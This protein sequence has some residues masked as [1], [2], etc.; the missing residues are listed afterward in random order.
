LAKPRE[1]PS[2]GDWCERGSVRC[3][4]KRRGKKRHIVQTREEIRGLASHLGLKFEAEAKVKM[5]GGAYNGKLGFIHA[6]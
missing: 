3:E 2:G 4:F 6:P 1:S 5:R